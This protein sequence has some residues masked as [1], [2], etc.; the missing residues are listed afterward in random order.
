MSKKNLEEQFD[1]YGLALSDEMLDKCA[2]LCLQYNIPDA[3][4]FVEN[5]M[6]YTINKLNGADPT[7]S[8]LGDMARQEYDKAKENK[9]NNVKDMQKMEMKT[10]ED[11]LKVYGNE[12]EDDMADEIMDSYFDSTSPKRKVAKPFVIKTPNTSRSLFTPA[13]YSPLPSTDS[14]SINSESGNVLCTF[15]RSQ[16]VKECQWTQHR[17]GILNIQL[18]NIG[19]GEYISTETRYMIDTLPMRATIEYE[20]MYKLGKEMCEHHKLIE[21]PLGN[22]EYDETEDIFRN[23][24]VDTPCLLPIECIGRIVI[25]TDTITRYNIRLVGL[26]QEEMHSVQLDL[27]KCKNY[28]LYPGQV[29]LVRGVNVRGDAIVVDQIKSSTNVCYSPAPKITS[30]PLSIVAAA[31]PYTSNEDLFFQPLQEL[32]KYCHENPPD[33]LIMTG[34]FLNVKGTALINMANRFDRHFDRMIDQLAHN[35]SCHTHI[36]IISS[37]EDANSSFVYPTHP[38]ESEKQNCNIHF[39]PD[40]CVVDIEG[41]HIGITSVDTIGM[42]SNNELSLN[43]GSDPIKRSIFHMFHKKTFYPLRPGSIPLDIGLAHKFAKLNVLPHVLILPSD[44][45]EFIRDYNNCLC[46]NPGHIYTEQGTGKFAKFVIHPTDSPTA[47]YFNYVA[48]QVV[49]I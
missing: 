32:V 44:L 48:G 21:K 15:G 41:L 14:R 22:G 10:E 33:V 5:W 42:L 7:M 45:K 6:A 18:S 27:S 2:E 1:Q 28:S 36:L 24:Q 8:T 37:H 12:G 19:N 38:Y 46:I 29:V 30:K 23:T 13:S 47:K 20:E 35:L 3:G 43:E 11:V 25:E 40:P 49:K 9:R 39:L 31:G 16:L 26:N 17:N 4:E 34:P